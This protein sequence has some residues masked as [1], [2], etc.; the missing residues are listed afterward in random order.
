MDAAMSTKR[1]PTTQARTSQAKSELPAVTDKSF[2]KE[3]AAEIVMGVRTPDAVFKTF[4]LS[5]DDW[6]CIQKDKE[7][8]QCVVAAHREWESTSST[9]QRVRVQSAA[10][11][12]TCWLPQARQEL[13]SPGQPLSARNETAK[14]ITKLAG[15]GF[16]ERH[17]PV[18]EN[19]TITITIPVRGGDPIKFV[20]D[21]TPKTIDHEGEDNEVD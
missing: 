20:K 5:P 7:F 3:L 19:I 17:E 8:R 13:S 2:Y 4:N 14:I 1:T 9:E 21:V 11:I 10:I 12:E 16:S 18:P 6:A 15:H